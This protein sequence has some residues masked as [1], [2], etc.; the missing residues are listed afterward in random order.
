[1]ILLALS[2]AL[3]V[4]P[5]PTPEKP[6]RARDAAARDALRKEFDES[7]KLPAEQVKAH[8]AAATFPGAVPPEATRITRKVAVDAAVAGWHSTGLYAAP[9]EVVS[10]LVPAAADRKML[11]LRIGAHRDTLWKLDRWNRHPEVSLRWPVAAGETRVASPFGGL[12]YVDLSGPAA[13]EVEIRGAVEAPRFALGRT[14]AEEWKARVRDLPAPWA[15]LETKKLVLTVPARVAKALDDPAAL[16]EF[17]DRVMDGLADIVGIPR[18]RPRPERIVP[19][20]QISAGWMHSGYPIMTHLRG[21]AEELVDLEKLRTWGSDNVWGFYHE[22][23]HNHQ[24]SPWTFSGTGEVTNNV[25]VL[26]VLDQVCKLGARAFERPAK[27]CP[28]ERIR[29]HLAEGAPFEKWK[30]DPWLALASYVQLQAG[31]GWEPFKKVFAEYRA[32]APGTLPRNDDEKRDQWMTRFS[33]AAGRNL[34][35]FFQA[36]GIPTSE[37]ARRSIEALPAWMPPGF[38][39]K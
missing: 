19:D 23:G 21:V 30:A 10:V 2:L 25:L 17:W 20:V 37:A 38:P 12:V 24:A 15:E 33:R 8:P 28:P 36:W 11:R 1:V 39:P 16:L 5:V 14:T 22:L 27:E 3:Q 18:E 29:K 34:G 6:L 32:A 31:F 35:P 13:L 9:G 26:Y 4:A 7:L